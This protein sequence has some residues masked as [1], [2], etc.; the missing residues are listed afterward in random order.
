MIHSPTFTIHNTTLFSAGPNLFRYAIII[1]ILLVFLLPLVSIRASWS[2]QFLSTT[3]TVDENKI[4]RKVPKELFGFNHNW[5]QSAQ[6]IWDKKKMQIFPE[7]ADILSGLSMPLNRMSGSVSQVFRWKQAIGPKSN[8]VRQQLAAYDAN[9][10]KYFGPLEWIETTRAIDPTAEFSWV[11]NLKTE[12]PSDHADLV[13]FLTG[14]GLINFN[15]GINWAKKRIEFGLIDPVP[16]KIWELGNEMDWAGGKAGWS[17]K[18]YLFECKKVIKAVHSIDSDAAIAVHAASAPMGQRYRFRDWRKWHRTLLRELGDEIDYIAF[19]AYYR[20][21]IPSSVFEKYL[22]VIRDDILNITGNNHIKIYISEHAVWPTTPKN[23]EKKWKENWH[24]THSLAGCLLT[25]QFINRLLQR[26]EV[27]AAAYHSFS[28]GP[29]GI[30]FAGKDN[31]LYRTGIFDLFLLFDNA[32]GD[33]VVYSSV[34]GIGTDISKKTLTFT[35]TAMT[36]VDGIH[37]IMVNREAENS[38]MI[39]FQFNNK[40]SIA[41]ITT[42]SANSIESYNRLSDRSI[43]SKIEHLNLKTDFTN[44]TMPAK[45]IVFIKLVN[46]NKRE[47]I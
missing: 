9:E 28:A 25:A 7:A 5:I 44:Y 19:H 38:R 16:I 2:Q 34:R 26:D 37:L 6:L 1:E 36:S 30:F 11:F 23:K 20:P 39:E 45:S 12:T 31:K 32:I 14:N 46:C 27:E 17:L 8:R 3:V 15:G 42:L 4:I 35:V 21:N 43:Y 40:Y 33:D 13:E 22:N 47:A 29:W 18:K 10:K 41:E 24:E